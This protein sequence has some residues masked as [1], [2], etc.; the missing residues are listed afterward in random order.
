MT[1]VKDRSEAGWK[2]LG[3]VIDE[4]EAV[5][6]PYFLGL[7]WLITLAGWLALWWKLA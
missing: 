3:G 6:A 4:I 5:L 7:V 2:S 1:E